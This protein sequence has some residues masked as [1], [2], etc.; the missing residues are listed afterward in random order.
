MSMFLKINNKCEVKKSQNCYNLKAVNNLK[1]GTSLTD[2]LK[3]QV[4]KE[5]SDSYSLM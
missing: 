3:M 1:V 2:Y 5:I 4:F